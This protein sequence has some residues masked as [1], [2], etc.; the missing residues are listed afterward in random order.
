[1]LADLFRVQ[2]EEFVLTEPGSSDT[3]EE[4]RNGYGWF[5]LSSPLHGWAY[6]K[7]LTDASHG[8]CSLHDDLEPGP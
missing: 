6:S 7:Y 1:M 8:D 2:A 3:E 4:P 5:R